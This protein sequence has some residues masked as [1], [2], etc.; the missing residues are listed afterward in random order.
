LGVWEFNP[1]PKLANAFGV[2]S[3]ASKPVI[4][5]E[6]NFVARAEVEL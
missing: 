5:V 6:L 3:D 4:V 2:L 1:E